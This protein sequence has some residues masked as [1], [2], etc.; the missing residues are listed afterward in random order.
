MGFSSLGFP[1][2][3][4]FYAMWAQFIDDNAPQQVNISA[5]FRIALDTKK[6]E[7]DAGAVPSRTVFTKVRF[8]IGIIVY[9]N[10]LY[11]C[12]PFL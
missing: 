2:L 10:F 4:R 7:I 9:R 12:A 11:V 1:F 8:E 5:K 3:N 6:R